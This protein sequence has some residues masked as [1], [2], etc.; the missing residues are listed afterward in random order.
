MET[1]EITS[2]IEYITEVNRLMEESKFKFKTHT[3]FFRGH[4]DEQ[5]KLRPSL[6]RDEG[7]I[8]NEHLM[9][10]TIIAKQTSEF[11]TCSSALDHLVKMQHYGMPTRLLDLTTN[12][13]VALFFACE[14][15]QATRSSVKGKTGEVIVLKVPI[16]SIKHYDSDT[17]SVIANVAKC[18]ENE[19]EI[20]LY[21][22]QWSDGNFYDG[23]DLKKNRYLHHIGKYY[24]SSALKELDGKNNVSE[25][26]QVLLES[27]SQFTKE[28]E[29][30]GFSFRGNNGEFKENKEVQEEVERIV[31]KLKP[32]KQDMIKKILP[33]LSKETSLEAENYRAWF[34][35][36]DKIKLLLHQISLEKSHFL[37]SIIP[38]DLSRVCIVHSKQDNQRIRNQMGYFVLFGLGLLIKEESLMLSK[39]GEIQI[40]EEWNL[41]LQTKITIAPKHK[42]KIID[43]L[44]LLG[45][46]RSFIYP[47]LETLSEELKNQYKKG[48]RDV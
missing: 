31:K 5:W 15:H 41:S 2:V 4:A 35:E 45:I 47:E 19:M 30:D 14:T 22:D 33:S 43:E 46:S 29:L 3:A 34:N 17:V 10:R 6:L 12:P 18:K 20:G 21:S 32:Y 38:Q 25:R 42:K 11:T 23:L 7:F 8:E 36:L 1:K 39:K 9:Y 24:A 44:A 48:E 37:P 16:H 13:L 40:P 28:N 27:L 26:A